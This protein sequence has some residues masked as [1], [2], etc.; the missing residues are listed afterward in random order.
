M[1]NFKVKCMICLS[2]GVAHSGNAFPG[3][4]PITGFAEQDLIV[5]VETHIA[6]A[7]I[8]DHQQ[9]VTPQV[10]GKNDSAMM[11]AVYMQPLGGLHQPAVP[12]D[13]RVAYCPEMPG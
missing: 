7:V 1:S 8:N 11:D 10:V 5:G 12:G 2:T 4:H 6:F 9:S 3:L 13:I